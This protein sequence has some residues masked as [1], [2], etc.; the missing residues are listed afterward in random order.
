MSSSIPP[1]YITIYLTKQT[2]LSDHVVKTSIVCEV[3]SYMIEVNQRFEGSKR[4]IYYYLYN[5]Q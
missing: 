5:S 3:K 4:I 2:L 1:L